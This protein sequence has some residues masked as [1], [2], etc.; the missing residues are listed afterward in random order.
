MYLKLFPSIIFTTVRCFFESPIYAPVTMTPFCH[1]LVFCYH[2]VT[3]YD[4]TTETVQRRQAQSSNQGIL[5]CDQKCHCCHWID[6]CLLEH[7][8]IVISNDNLCMWVCCS[9]TLL[10]R[11][12]SLIF[13]DFLNHQFMAQF[14]WHHFFT[15]LSQLSIFSP[16]RHNLRW[17]NRNYTATTSS[18]ERSG[19]ITM[20]PK[21]SLLSLN[22]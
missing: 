18:I 8:G 21:S 20:G 16:F 19:N 2:F 10:N 14:Q 13:D 12:Y 15:I 4:D 9:C 7:C 3:I 1:N 22:R 5:Q 11:L 17:D 6:E